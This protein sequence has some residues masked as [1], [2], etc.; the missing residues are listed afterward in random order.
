VR[1]GVMPTPV[2]IA[3]NSGNTSNIII[4]FN[5]VIFFIVTKL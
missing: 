1:T 2:I 3:S 4:K 5:Y